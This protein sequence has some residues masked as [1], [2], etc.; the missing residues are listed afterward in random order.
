MLKSL[1]MKQLLS[2][3]VGAGLLGAAIL[4]PAVKAEA[5]LQINYDTS[6]FENVDLSAAEVGVRVSY[7][8]YRELGEGEENNLSYQLIYRGEEQETVETFAWAFAE[9]EL[10]DLNSDGLEE[11]IVN[12]YS[13]GAHCCTNTTIYSWTEAG[14]AATE[15]G[16]I[17]G[18]GARLEDL[19]GDE[20]AEIIIPHQ[21]FLYRFGS[22]A[23]SYPPDTIFTYQAGELIEVTREF[24]DHIRQ[25]AEAIK[26]TFFEVQASY[27]IRSNALLASYV[28]QQAVLNENF[29]D[30]WQFMLD[31]YDREL[32]WGLE[33]YE[34]GEQAG[35][36]PDFP[37]ALR[38]FLIETR[39]LGEDGLPRDRD[40]SLTLPFQR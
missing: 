27:D 1:M 33:I 14:F 8:H 20:R 17:D 12:N 18:R 31:N 25:Q 22:Y 28:A 39:Y 35:A 30:A 11:V 40:P 2:G 38:A 5:V 32:T 9:F 16:F 26:E 15:T 36:Y 29:D 23:E 34:D 21:G 24:S 4:A 7:S 13:G 19:N 3:L 6:S 10:R 37:T